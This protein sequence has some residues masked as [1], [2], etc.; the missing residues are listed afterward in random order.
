[1]LLNDDPDVSS[2]VV[3]GNVVKATDEITI[4]YLEVL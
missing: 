2:E 1:M 4:H 3:F